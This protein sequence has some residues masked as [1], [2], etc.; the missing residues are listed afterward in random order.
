MQLFTNTYKKVHYGN[1]WFL[2]LRK[3]PQI[4]THD[5]TDIQPYKMRLQRSFYLLKYTQSRRCEI[6]FMYEPSPEEFIVLRNWANY[7]L[8][9]EHL[10]QHP[11]KIVI[12]HLK[13]Y[14]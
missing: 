13:P 10:L 2:L 4:P 1:V 8:N 3:P 5:I 14:Q 7:K 11:R 6:T 12:V 9:V